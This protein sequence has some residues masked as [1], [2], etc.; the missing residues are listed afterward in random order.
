MTRESASLPTYQA[1]GLAY[2]HSEMTKFK[3]ATDP[4]FIAVAAE[5]RR[6]SKPLLAKPKGISADFVAEK[7]PLEI[8]G[9]V[10]IP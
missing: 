7:S 3:D 2:N 8:I 4:G 9:N 5:L 10:T 1:T 6:W